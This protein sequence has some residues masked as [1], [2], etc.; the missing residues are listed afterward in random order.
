MPVFARRVTPGGLSTVRIGAGTV[1][2]MVAT[3]VPK[4]GELIYKKRIEEDLTQEELS[5]LTGYS[6]T[7]ISRFERG[8]VTRDAADI[9]APWLGMSIRRFRAMID[10]AEDA[11]RPS[12]QERARQ[13]NGGYVNTKTRRG[14]RHRR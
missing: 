9:L 10:D 4:L 3:P 7:S 13:E 11:A 5:A 2:Q 14:P 12:G 8:E 6:Q 1:G